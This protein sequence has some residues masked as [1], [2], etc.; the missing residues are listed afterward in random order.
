MPG[1]PYVG[2][3][4]DGRYFTVELPEGSAEWDPVTNEIVLQA[5]AIHLLDKLRTVLSPLPSKHTGSRLRL[6]R[7]SLDLSTDQL[8]NAIQEEPATVR[9]WEANQSMP[10]S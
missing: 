1:Q 5:S 4:S 8:A 2:R 3:L 7:E 10:T 6:L 9:D